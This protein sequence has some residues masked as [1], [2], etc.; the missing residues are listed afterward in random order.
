MLI[1]AF[2]Q[3]LPNLAPVPFCLK[4]SV[5]SFPRT[6]FSFQFFDQ[7]DLFHGLVLVS[8]RM[9]PA[10]AKLSFYLPGKARHITKRN[11]LL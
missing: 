7:R 10:M 11:K 4:K 3:L 6:W 1:F 2:A 9:R 8:G 5:L